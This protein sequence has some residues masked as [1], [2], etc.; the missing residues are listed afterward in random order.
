MCMP[1]CSLNS[2]PRSRLISVKLST[3]PGIF[4]ICS[5]ILLFLSK[6][7]LFASTSS[8][9]TEC[10]LGAFNTARINDLVARFGIA[11]RFV[12]AWTLTRS[13]D[14]LPIV[15]GGRSDGRRFLRLNATLTP[16]HM[17]TS[18]VGPHRVH[19]LSPSN[20][21]RRMY[22]NQ[23]ARNSFSFT[24]GIFDPRRV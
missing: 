8:R 18:G 2:F 11:C 16:S 15:V 4:E 24:K 23:P 10:S 20:L 12:T 7:E 22:E 9:L 5:T 21:I 6:V 3:N 19:I 14:V 17:V 13:T 1:K